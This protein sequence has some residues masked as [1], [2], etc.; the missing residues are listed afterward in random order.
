MGI[1]YK[2]SG[3]LLMIYLLLSLLGSTLTLFE[4]YVLKHLLDTLVNENSNLD[5]TIF[6]IVIYTLSLVVGSAN[7][8]LQQILYNLIFKK[9]EHLYECNLN[10]KLLE[11]PLS[12]I[13]ASEG[14]NMI[15][16]VRHSKIATVYC[17]QN[18]VKVISHAYSFIAAFFILFN[19][20]PAFSLLF[21]LLTVPGII[22]NQIFDG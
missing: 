14:K 16:D 19:F 20:N 17:V 9:A 6:T 18:M 2:S 5:T 11:L 1:I 13:D 7:I 4:T 3:I 8:S 12:I 22:L 15:D 21:L 10:N